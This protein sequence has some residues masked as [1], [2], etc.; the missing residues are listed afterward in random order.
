MWV[1]EKRAHLTLIPI[2]CVTGG[3]LRHKKAKEL[4]Q[5]HFTTAA[6]SWTH[7]QAHKSWL[8]PTSFEVTGERQP[9][10]W[11]EHWPG[12][13]LLSHE[14]SL[15]KS[16]HLSAPQAASLSMG[17]HCASPS[18]WEITLLATMGRA[19]TRLC[20]HIL[21]CGGRDTTASVSSVSNQDHACSPAE[22]AP[23]GETLLL[24]QDPHP[25]CL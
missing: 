1:E 17:Q 11:G 12:P 10:P 5:D 19:R 13:P 6:Q 4:A 21:G 20:L 3:E 15:S 16:C 24:L 14:V 2:D 7:T 8:T 9:L 18:S 25:G 23:W 22:P